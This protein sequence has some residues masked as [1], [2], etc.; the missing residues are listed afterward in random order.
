M[1]E[2]QDKIVREPYKYVGEMGKIF[3]RR[4]GYNSRKNG[5]NRFVGKVGILVGEVGR[6]VGE[7]GRTPCYDT[8][9]ETWVKHQTMTSSCVVDM[10]KTHLEEEKCRRHGKN[11]FRGGKCRTNG[12]SEI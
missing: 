2:K 11:T 3:C 8:L 10:G 9:S 6:T 4:S 5:Y 7:V 1:S 12:M